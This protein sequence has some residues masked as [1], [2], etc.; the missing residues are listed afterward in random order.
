MECNTQLIDLGEFCFTWNIADLPRLLKIK[1]TVSS[2]PLSIPGTEGAVCH[3]V[4]TN[5]N[6]GHVHPQMQVNGV[7]INTQIG[8]LFYIHLE[9]KGAM[10]LAGCVDVS[11]C[12]TS[13]RGSFGDKKKDQFTSLNSGG[14]FNFAI[15]PPVKYYYESHRQFYDLAAFPAIQQ[16]KPN[17]IKLSLF[18]PEAI[19]HTLNS[20]T[21]GEKVGSTELT[22]NMRT[23]LLDHKHSDVVL[24]CQKE[25]FKCHK[26]IL[27][28]RSPVFC[29][30]FDVDMDE[31]NRGVVD[32]DD[33]NPEVLKAI[34]E[35]IYT[36]EDVTEDVDDLATLVYAGDKYELGGLLDLCYE[37]FLK[38]NDESKLAEMLI[39][40]DRHNLDNIKKE[41]MARITKD[42]NK[43]LQDKEFT[44]QMKKN[45]ELL[46]EIMCSLTSKK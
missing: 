27:G 41:A 38:I 26:S 8:A 17:E 35:F 32:I 2:P 31:S 1:G 39:G 16:D 45:P 9:S 46:V 15:N 6:S 44:K 29:R 3:L 12:E 11:C 40:A 42:A 36:G 30:M 4:L 10:Q 23:L 22:R 21:K 25:K 37:K 43:F 13:V 7:T 24:Y 28:A 34:I 5:Y 33:M 18:S 14:N 20:P 19:S